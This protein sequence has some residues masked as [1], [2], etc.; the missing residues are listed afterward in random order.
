M[1]FKNGLQV[2]RNKG[3]S[4]ALRLFPFRILSRSFS[5]PGSMNIGECA[6]RDSHKMDLQEYLLN[7]T[8]HF[9]F[10]LPIKHLA[11]FFHAKCSDRLSGF[12]AP[13]WGRRERVWLYGTIVP[14]CSPTFMVEAGKRREGFAH[15]SRLHS[16]DARAYVRGAIWQGS[17]ELNRDSCEIW[18]PLHRKWNEMNWICG[19][20]VEKNAWNLEGVLTT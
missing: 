13:I 8:P 7:M 14:L 17:A 20:H 16:F 9:S 15:S 19:R 10:P 6:R 3:I 11:L 5:V 2:G 12:H 18:Y 4:S 1:S